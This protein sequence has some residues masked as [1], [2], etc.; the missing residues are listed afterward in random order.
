MIL[1]IF[2]RKSVRFY[3]ASPR[4]VTSSY[5][6]LATRL[7]IHPRHSAASSPVQILLSYSS[8]CFRFFTGERFGIT[9]FAPACRPF[10]CRVDPSY[11]VLLSPEEVPSAAG[12]GSQR[13]KTVSSRHFLPVLL[14]RNYTRHF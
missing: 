10:P 1:V 9:T 13:A 3:T 6:T 5:P 8:Y 12:F 11:Q 2:Y 4:S 7:P 14:Q